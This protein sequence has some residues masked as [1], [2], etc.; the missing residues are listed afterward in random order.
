[1]DLCVSDNCVIVLSAIWYTRNIQVLA[2]T[3]T[4]HVILLSIM[5]CFMM[6]HVHV[7][8]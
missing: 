7:H 5:E 6:G 4:C 8:V 2:D 3:C 1:M